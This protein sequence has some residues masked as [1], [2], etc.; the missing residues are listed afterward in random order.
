MHSLL[1]AGTFLL[2]FWVG[3]ANAAIETEYTLEYSP[4]PL[5]SGDLATF[6]L[7][8][9]AA[10][11]SSACPQ[12][13]LTMVLSEYVEFATASA[14]GEHTADGTGATGGTVFWDKLPTFN[15]NK[16]G[17]VIVTGIIQSGLPA[18]EPIVLD[19]SMGG[20][21]GE[22]C[23]DAIFAPP[24]NPAPVLAVTKTTSKEIVQPGQSIIYTIDFENTGNQAAENVVVTD[25][26]PPD[27]EYVSASNDPTYTPGTPDTVSWTIPVLDVD[28][29]VSRV[30]EV[31]VVDTTPADTVITNSVTVTGEDESGTPVDD[32]YDETQ[33]VVTSKPLLQISKTAQ[34]TVLSGGTLNYEITYENTGDTTAVSV[35][36]VDTY[37]DLVADISSIT[38]GG[39][40]NEAANTITW[41]LGDLLP[42]QSGQLTYTAL[43]EDG[44]LAFSAS[45]ESQAPDTV[46]N[47]AVISADNADDNS[48]SHSAGVILPT[49]S[50]EILKL[51]PASADAG[52]TIEYRLLYANV[53]SADSIDTVVE[54]FAPQQCVDVVVD[55][56]AW[57]PATNSARWDIGLLAVNQSGEVSLTCQLDSPIAD[58]TQITNTG[59]IFSENGSPSTSQVVTVIRSQPLISIEK[60]GQ[61]DPVKPG[62]QL[63]YTY[64]I[65]NT[66]NA[67]ATEVRI[68]D[69]LDDNVSYVSDTFDGSFSETEN[70]ITWTVETLTTSQVLEIV[71]LAD[72]DPDLTGNV[73]LDNSVTVDSAETEAVST[74]ESVQVAT[75]PQ[76][77]LGKTASKTVVNPG[78]ELTYT[79]SYA[80]SGNDVALNV[81]LVDT[82]PLEVS[83]LGS[84][85][86]GEEVDGLVTWDL[87]DV[88]VGA[89]GT[90]TLSVRV[91]NPLDNNTTIF[92]SASI[93]SDDTQPVS[94]TNTVTVASQAIL[95]LEKTGDK[96]VAAIGDNV[97]YELSY[98]NTGNANATNVLLTDSLP[99]KLSFVSASGGGTHADGVIS[100][101][102]DSLT[103]GSSGTVSFVA[104][105]DGPASNGEVIRNTASM[106]SDQT[107]PVSAFDDITV[108]YR[109]ILSLTKTA[110]KTIASAGDEIT[111]V[112][113]I[114]NTGNTFATGVV[115]EDKIPANTS[116][117]SATQGYSLVDDVVSWSAEQL[118][119]GADGQLTLTVKIADDAEDD[120][121]ISN[122]ASISSDQTLPL[123]AGDLVIVQNLPRFT[124]TKETE[125]E[126]V[127]AGS[128]VL[129]NLAYQN[130]GTAVGTNVIL[131]DIVP[132]DM[133]YVSSTGGGI[134]DDETNTVTWTDP[135]LAPGEGGQVQLTLRVNGSAPDGTVI[136]NTAAISADLA[137][138]V[139]ASATVT[140]K[141][142]PVLELVKSANVSSVLP[143][144]EI[145]YTLQFS[146]SGNATAY[147][148]LLEDP[149]P[150]DTTLVSVSE[151]GSVTDGIVSWSFEQLPVGQDGSV[152]MVVRVNPTAVV[153]SSELQ[154]DS[155]FNSA[156]ID[157]PDANS[158]TSSITIPVQ[159]VPNLVLTKTAGSDF[160]DAGEQVSFVLDFSNEGNA[161]A[162]NPDISDRIP[163]NMTF[164][165]AS[166]GYVF[167]GITVSWDAPDLP[168][169]ESGQVF[170]IM[171]VKAGTADGTI[172]DNIAELNADNSAVKIASDSIEVR[173]SPVLKLDKQA[174]RDFVG[175]GEVIT[176]ELTYSNSGNAV[177]ADVTLEDPIP[178]ETTL[179]AL[180]P[181]AVLDGDTVVWT[182]PTLGIGAS[183]SVSLSVRVNPEAPLDTG[184][185]DGTIIHNVATLD[186]P[187]TPATS[188][189]DDVTVKVS[190]L[191][192]LEKTASSEVVLAGEE[193]T[194]SIAFNN[195]GNGRA[196]SVL[197]TDS[198]P[199]NMSYVSSPG[200]TLN[201]GV[202]E[203]DLGTLAAGAQGS[204][205]LTLLVDSDTPDGSSIV[206]TAQIDSEETAPVSDSATIEV[207]ARPI[208]SLT[209]AADRELAGPGDLITFV[210]EY[211]NTGNAAANNLVLSDQVPDLTEFVSA[212]GGGE[213]AGG[214]VTWTEPQ[215]L[216]GASASVSLTVR[217]SVA[218]VVNTA[219]TNGTIVT[220]IATLTSDNGEPQIAQDS[221]AIQQYP[222][223]NLE[224]IADASV[225]SPGDTVTYI[226][227]YGNTGNLDATPVTLS[228]PI[229]QYTTFLSATGG[230]ELSG[231]SVLWDFDNLPPGYFGAVTFTVQ[232]DNPIA[233]EVDSGISINNT[234]TLDAGAQAPPVSSS[235]QVLVD[236]QPVPGLT[237]IADVEYAQPEENIT[238]TI[239]FSNTGNTA[240]TN[241]TLTDSIPP[242]TQFVSASNGGTPQGQTVVWS[243]GSLAAGAQGS[244]TLVVAVDELVPD[245]TVVLNEAVLDSGDQAP[246]VSAST[247]VLI[248][249]AAD[250]TLDKSASALLIAPGDNIIYTLTYSN[251]GNAI[252]P[253][254]ELIEAIPANTAFVAASDGGVVNGQN[255]EWT[256]GDLA[257]GDTGFVTMEVTAN[258]VVSGDVIHNSAT[259][260]SDATAPVESSAKV[261]VYSPEVSPVQLDIDIEGRPASIREGSEA[262]YF[263]TY[264]NLTDIE[265][266]NPRVASSLPSN[267]DFVSASDGGTLDP[268]REPALVRWSLPPLP[269]NAS[270][271]VSF[272]VRH[273]SST[274]LASLTLLQDDIVMA[275]FA[276]RFNA[277]LLNVTPPEAGLRIGQSLVTIGGVE[278]DNAASP[279]L[280]SAQVQIIERFRPQG[281]PLAGDAAHVALALLLML[282]GMM[283]YLRRSQVSK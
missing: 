169:G 103:V 112:L 58:G 249:A 80:N 219:S 139:I 105:L 149:V 125:S 223:L 218:A 21:N 213:L 155:I 221:V 131:E 238:Y 248:E 208:L 84:S 171:E 184:V 148:V 156:S 111:Y 241:A 126:F 147:D 48:A 95:F 252:A 142:T 45:S 102:P 215:L 71:M 179:E 115:V 99:G 14:D 28:E 123:L 8:Y 88:P 243:I 42:G 19:V 181:N 231:G 159:Q 6:T 69:F 168:A 24:A 38:G 270:R 141:R 164:V 110:N 269:G 282:L 182:F 167:D 37:S 134:Y 225:V 18:N 276:P 132:P 64:R 217:V 61:P 60:T 265:A 124:L 26:L 11:D 43:I 240:I 204:V 83:Y 191:L 23:G 163:T 82:L 137:V 31:R 35:Q 183:G 251:A 281:V 33:T 259:L 44:L 116:F 197:I 100:W 65:S 73:T 106:D 46:D 246:P 214:I 258:A 271:T 49:P 275:S 104:R 136:E 187:T 53:G 177:A 189:Q 90:I 150:V 196:D 146:N 144:D 1:R 245:G 220:N 201:G 17:E 198:I 170:V 194:Y 273:Q 158:A 222:I 227:N 29:P 121:V 244:V 262:T 211:A 140:V 41:A 30:I 74:E 180:P 27:T 176:Y 92:N 39:V 256:L 162:I 97:T 160:V 79:L 237:K 129:F 232:V 12:P 96:E 7:S 152:S 15:Q 242:N 203:W 117:V 34:D 81:V 175:P 283:Y 54:D 266:E 94:A 253:G 57:D 130:T 77:T 127:E 161:A 236:A 153:N 165:S 50:L 202:V 40:E 151:G 118:P 250:L 228:D 224:K 51:G 122:V 86:G 206:N 233:K 234:A 210:L 107:T 195:A 9:I 279:V 62:E 254:A 109:P 212:T 2:S 260:D 87:G 119:I 91:A 76:L 63:R 229:P 135:G 280:A 267:A 66:G 230:G 268:G 239:G 166:P 277:P 89:Q 145:V 59:S 173:S 255:V 120:T 133:D 186:T 138:G 188:A 68:E 5:L 36:I 264:T 128:N 247:E 278:A 172:I 108:E 85:D 200:G 93:Q 25:E 235:A 263:I 190:P 3:I 209:K 274:A 67:N 4:D 207:S 55:G 226:L 193:V 56:G 192:Q 199:T 16:S 154:G 174:D 178:A 72:V 185:E 78:E 261:T 22:D 101:P 20:N 10:E 114:S 13:E 257:P 216:P 52:S 113:D 75:E 32:A 143:G 47:T 272:T 98:G 157:S 205:T 70:T